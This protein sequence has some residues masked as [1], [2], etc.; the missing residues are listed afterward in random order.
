MK[1]LSP[2]LLFLPIV[3]GLFAQE[4]QSPDTRFPVR[5]AEYLQGF[6]N[7]VSGQE[8]DYPPIL[9]KGK[10]ALL[11]T[12]GGK[13]FEFETAPVPSGN[14]ALVTFIWQAS[15]PKTGSEQP[16]RFDFF[17]NGSKQFSFTRPR[18]EAGKDWLLKNG[19][20]ELAFIATEVEDDKGNYFGYQFLTV[21]RK[22][23]PAG[24]PLLIKIAAE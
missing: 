8:L 17:I 16:A 20:L 22:D 3:L 14:E 19:Q 21:P 15:L 12:P 5:S 4:Q 24:K 2:T 10:L 11:T 23:F 1:K 9:Q 13:P 7:I 18:N 6:V